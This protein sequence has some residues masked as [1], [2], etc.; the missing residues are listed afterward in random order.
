MT[1]GAPAKELHFNIL[2]VFYEA[3]GQAPYRSSTRRGARPRAG[4]GTGVD[5]GAV[6]GE[7]PDP[8]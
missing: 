4:V 5:T 7:E 1:I 8:V 3:G 6:P 2:I